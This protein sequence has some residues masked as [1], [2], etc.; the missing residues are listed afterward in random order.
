MAATHA[1]GVDRA[2]TLGEFRG[3]PAIDVEIC[4]SALTGM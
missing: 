2:Q 1:N 4:C 3:A